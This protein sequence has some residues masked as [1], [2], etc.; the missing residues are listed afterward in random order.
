M[1]APAPPKGLALMAKRC[2]P[3]WQHRIVHGRGVQRRQRRDRDLHKM[4]ATLDPC[5]SWSLRLRHLDGRAAVGVWVQ[6]DGGKAAFDSAWT[7]VVCMDP[8]CPHGVEGCAGTVPK[9][10]PSTVLSAYLSVVV[11]PELEVAA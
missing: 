10:C 6:P 5:S 2:A 1:I 9:T 8:E 3:G 4:I 11:A 7:W